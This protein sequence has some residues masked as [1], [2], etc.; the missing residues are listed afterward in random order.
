MELPATTPAP[1]VPAPN[2]VSIEQSSSTVSV[3][4]QYV[5]D[6]YGGNPLNVFVYP[7]STTAERSGPDGAY[8]FAGAPQEGPFMNSLTL[9]ES[10]F[11]P[12]T[13][14]AT[15]NVVAPGID[16]NLGIDTANMVPGTYAVDISYFDS[17][18]WHLIPAQTFTWQ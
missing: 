14:E 12:T 9:P 17:E 13:K 1:F 11:D 16:P 15:F 6:F 2:I 18:T 3:T 7:A 10:A 4:V 8:F 5:G